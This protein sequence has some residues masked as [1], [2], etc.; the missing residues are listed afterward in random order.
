MSNPFEVLR[1][2][3]EA[4]E[5]EAVQQAARLCQMAK[6]EAAR[7]VVR[8][9][10]QQ[11]T[12]SREA[13]ALAALLTHPRPEHHNV[14]VERFIAAHRR[15]PVTRGESVEVPEVDVEEL[16]GLRMDARAV[17]LT[18]GALGLERMVITE[19][20]EEI[21]RQTSEAVWLGLVGE[22]RG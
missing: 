8:Q 3:P 4:S 16:R 22:T 11:L 5:E 14:E 6:D 15:P 20:L 1:L 13:R 12:A 17:E 10:I 9:A 21:E 18:G 19:S 2:S 7:N